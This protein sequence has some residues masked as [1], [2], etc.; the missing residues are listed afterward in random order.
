MKRKGLP[1]LP[2]PEPEGRFP[3]TAGIK[4]HDTN[5]A[6]DADHSPRLPAA[7]VTKL[8]SGAGN[9]NESSTFL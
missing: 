5:V 4:T 7:T 9:T 1:L 3:T 8:N 6:K 2:Y